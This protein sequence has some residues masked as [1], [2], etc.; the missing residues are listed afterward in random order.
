[1]ILEQNRWKILLFIAIS[2]IPL[3]VG[4]DA[5]WDFYNYHLY[6]AHAL[7]ND[8]LSQ[9]FMAASM[10]GYLNPFL[11]LPTYWMIMADWP[12]VFIRLALAL[13]HSLNILLLWKIFEQV[14]APGVNNRNY[15]VLLG[16]LLGV[17]APVFLAT[18]GTTFLDPTISVLV[19]FGLLLLCTGTRDSANFSTGIG[20]A[21]LFLGMAAG[22]KP[23]NAIYVISA[24]G[25]LLI[26]L[27]IR[28][29][30]LKV[31]FY[32]G[33]AAFAGWLI[34]GGWW[35]WKLYAE[36]RNPFFPMFN[37]IFH[38]PDFPADLLYV[39]RFL[40]RGILEG[41]AQLFRMAHY[42]SGIYAEPMLP[43]LRPALIV[44]FA[45]I[46]FTKIS[47]GKLRG[48]NVGNFETDTPR[49]VVLW[50]FLIA[51]ALWLATSG[52]GRYG[53][54]VLLLAGPVLLWLIVRSVPG[55]RWPL[56]VATAILIAQNVH[57]WGT[58][59]GAWDSLPWARKWVDISVPKKLQQQPYLY[60]TTELQTDSFVVPFVH[61]KAA[62]INLLGQYPIPPAGPG[63]ER[64]KGLV[65]QHAG[66]LRMMV[67]VTEPL[68]RDMDRKKYLARLDESFSPWGLRTDESDCVSFPAELPWGNLTHIF[69]SCALQP[70]TRIS[71]D[72][73]RMRQRLTA[74]FG[75]LEKTCPLLF[76]PPGWHLERK[77]GMWSRKY[78][79]TD[80]ILYSAKGRMFYSHIE[81]G[82]F[83]VDIGSIEDWEAGKGNLRCER[84]PA[85]WSG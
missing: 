11:Y 23:T 10:Q 1:M 24:G 14:I 21:G 46:A 70:G 18:L 39:D 22:L 84:P 58:W 3:I 77:G 13:I 27:G 64:V 6:A 69:L 12:S 80:N 19:L 48:G 8:R 15:Y 68:F 59:N 33:I 85:P 26:M 56:L 44:I 54:P 49:G 52:N 47:W 45:G 51:A 71:D 28:S 73:S 7:V 16:V 78:M 32:F 31:L 74:V 9:D 20:I 40:P 82:P 61:P 79:N 83:D 81:Y 30:T 36:F 42:H 75:R 57:A 37:N 2:L 65:A 25:A 38:S 4:R 5:N 35:A 62:F 72:Y 17:S 43:D 76:G 53:L 29:R 50:F 41:L 34:T 67:R 55:G 60:F 63:S 66:R